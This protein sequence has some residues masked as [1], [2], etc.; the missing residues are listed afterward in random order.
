MTA[1]KSPVEHFTVDG[2]HPR[3]TEVIP[4]TTPQKWYRSLLPELEAR[5]VLVKRGA[6]WYGRRS[7]IEAAL[8]AAPTREAFKPH[9]V[10]EEKPPEYGSKEWRVRARRKR[11]DRR[12]AAKVRR[13][14]GP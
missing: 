2:S 1:S 8:I 7:D 14:I 13:V 12:R 4:G 9:S 10:V 5:G 6:A 3:L 11:S